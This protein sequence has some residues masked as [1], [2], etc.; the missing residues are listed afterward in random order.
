[1]VAGI[2]RAMVL[3]S[4]LLLLAIGLLAGR[5]EEG[6]RASEPETSQPV[7][8][9]SPGGEATVYEFVGEVP[10]ARELVAVVADK[11][12]G[13]NGRRKVQAYVCDGE[14]QGDVEWF[15]GEAVSNTFDLT[16]VTK[17]ARLRAELIETEAVG[18]IT[19]ADGSSR[20]FE[21]PAAR[22]G[23]GLYEVTIATGG[24]RSGISAN[25]AKD[26]GRVSPDGALTTGAIKLPD[27]E[28]IDYRTRR[29]TGYEGG[30]KPNTYTTIVLP[31]A[32]KERGRGRDVKTKGPSSN[33]D[34]MISISKGL[35]GLILA[36]QPSCI[37]LFSRTLEVISFL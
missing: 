26:E 37:R 29:T 16:S 17:T 20:R 8:S 28:T 27:G 31:G 1:M 22:D 5:G 7:T 19:L 4:L 12:V 15:A 13:A 34:R 3:V 24:R 33:F 32:A 18:T 14:P 2:V 25:G 23:A 9:Q 10:G 11:M 21:A 30:S 6:K 35:V 36:V